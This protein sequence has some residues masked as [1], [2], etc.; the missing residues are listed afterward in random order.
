[1]SFRSGGSFRLV[2]RELEIECALP[3]YLHPGAVQAPGMFYSLAVD[4]GGSGQDLAGEPDRFPGIQVDLQCQVGLF[5]PAAIALLQRLVGGK[6]P[7]L[8]PGGVLLPDIIG[9]IGGDHGKTDV[10]SGPHPIFALEMI[11]VRPPRSLISLL[12]HSPGRCVQHLLVVPAGQIQLPHRLLGQNRTGLIPGYHSKVPGAGHPETVPNPKGDRL[13]AEGRWR[14]KRQALAQG[15]SIGMAQG[16]DQGFSVNPTGTGGNVHALPLES[17]QN[18]RGSED[19]QSSVPS[20]GWSVV[21]RL[22]YLQQSEHDAVFPFQGAGIQKSIRPPVC[23]NVGIKS[24][25]ANQPRFPGFSDPLFD[26]PFIDAHFNPPISIGTTLPRRDP[27]KECPH[28]P[29]SGSP[30]PVRRPG[31]YNRDRAAGT[32][33]RKY[34]WLI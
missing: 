9:D 25:F 16:T 8:T 28:L 31:P 1:M 3:F 7:G 22:R 15:H 13:V 27:R 34:P 21:R 18:F 20:E 30:R 10:Q 26:S 29:D 4:Q 6:Y 5:D 24:L 2:D 14:S 11:P 12:E 19:P 23:C 32:S 17:L 33:S